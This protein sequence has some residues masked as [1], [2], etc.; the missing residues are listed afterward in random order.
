MSYAFLSGPRLDLRPF[1]AGDVDFFLK[2]MN[3]PETRGLIGETRPQS[4]MEAEKYIEKINSDSSRVWL[5]AVRREDGKIIGETGLL[6]MFSPWRTTDLTIIIPDLA[7][8]GKGYGTEAVNLMLDYAFGYLNFN[9]VAIGV[10]GFNAQALAFYRKIGFVEEGRQHEGYYYN[11]QYHD[12]VMMR[13]LARE[14]KPKA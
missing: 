7:E 5:A 2:W 6:R 14:F 1:E 4:R 8:Q 11:H 13:I 3:D 9:R 10:V 12:F